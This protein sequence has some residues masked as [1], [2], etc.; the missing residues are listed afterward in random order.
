MNSKEVLDISW[1]TILKLFL[2]AICLYVLYQIRDILVWFIF[3][4]IIS[5]LFNPLIDF[6]QRKKIPRSIGTVLVYL[7]FF[8]LFTFLIYSFVP[9][10][11]AEIKYFSQVFP[12]YFEKVSPLFRGLK[13]EAFE[14]IEN[15]LAFL[16]KTLEGAV[17]N[18]FNTLFT[19]FGGIASTIFILTIAI[20][21]SLEEKPVERTIYLLFPKKYE[22]YALSLWR[23]C[24]KGVSAWFFSRIIGCLFVGVLSTL[25][26][27]LF[28]TKYPFFFGLLAGGLNFVPVVGPLMTGILLFLVVVLENFWRAIFVLIA[29]IFIQQIENNILLP[30]LTKKFLGLSPVLVL[31]GLAIGGV[32]WGFLGAVLVVPLFGILYGFLREFLEKRKKESTVML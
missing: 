23:R 12:E 31:M 30:L 32:L 11:L 25:V 29:F 26:F 3:A 6:L 17:A 21:L 15:F 18:I 14:S 8:G 22:A 2:A 4:L 19:I 24:Q 20:F 5:I 16:S 27:L 10:F 7:G 9:L 28:N 13:V 1:G